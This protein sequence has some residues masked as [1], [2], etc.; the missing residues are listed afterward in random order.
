MSDWIQRF[1]E[2]MDGFGLTIYGE[3]VAN[4]IVIVLI[5]V[6]IV[7]FGTSLVYLSL[8]VWGDI[9]DSWRSDGETTRQS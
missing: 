9:K 6:L 5:L 4:L 8:A 3:F 1:N 2:A 7:F